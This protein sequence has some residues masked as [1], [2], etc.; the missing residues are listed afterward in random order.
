MCAKL[1]PHLQL[2]AI[3][4]LSHIDLQCARSA[5]GSHAISEEDQEAAARAYKLLHVGGAKLLAG[6]SS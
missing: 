3:F 6:C 5:D 4:L 1:L 2:R